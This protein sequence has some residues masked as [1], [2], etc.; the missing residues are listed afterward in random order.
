L[1]KL[2]R[3]IVPTKE[4]HNN[5]ESM[6]GFVLLTGALVLASLLGLGAYVVFRWVINQVRDIDEQ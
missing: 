2:R 1:V 4:H 5:G 6:S 3:W